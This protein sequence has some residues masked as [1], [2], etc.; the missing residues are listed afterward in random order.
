M[1]NR[2]PNFFQIFTLFDLNN[3]AIPPVKAFTA[4]VFVSIN[5]S[6]FNF[7]SPTVKTLQMKHIL[8][9]TI[10]RTT[11]SSPSTPLAAKSPE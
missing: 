9:F 2:Q 7:T 11:K 8:Y 1:P 5:F 4:L 6:K 10:T 3:E